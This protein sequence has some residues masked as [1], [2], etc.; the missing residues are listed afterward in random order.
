MRQGAA[1]AQGCA[2]ERLGRMGK[3]KAWT[4]RHAILESDLSG[5]TKHVL[6][7]ISC[8]MNELGEGNYRTTK[9]LAAFAGR[10]ERCVCEHIEIAK[11]AGWLIV[12]RHGFGGQKWKRHE[13][14]PAWPS[15][16][17]AA[18]EGTDGGSAPS[19]EGTDPHAEGTDPPSKKA[20]TEGQRDK[21]ISNSSHSLSQSAC[22]SGGEVVDWQEDKR[23]PPWVIANAPIVA[24][25]LLVP[26]LDSGIRFQGDSVF[27]MMTGLARRATAATPE[28]CACAV[29]LL[30]TDEK[31]KREKITQIGQVLEAL[32][33]GKAMA[34][35][36]VVV[37]LDDPRH[38]AAVAW[39]KAHGTNWHRAQVE[40]GQ[41]PS[42]P[43]GVLDSG[44]LNAFTS[45][46]A[47]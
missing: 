32:R 47:A 19:P 20:L 17:D 25:H 28:D 13:Y 24:E 15:D 39:V 2:G 14:L 44:A 38:A 23:L 41:A 9:E 12:S 43:R 34:Q 33:A 21:N 4:W 18:E 35:M 36:P 29:D 5:T 45:G 6:L 37:P 26:I 40:K 31:H 8:F 22:A 7:T 30:L 42:V 10:S 46:E 27:G 16:E 11:D 3:R 1:S